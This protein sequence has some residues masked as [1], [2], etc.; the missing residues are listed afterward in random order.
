MSAENIDN[1]SKK[2][3]QK[4]KTSSVGKLDLYIPFFEIALKWVKEDG[5]LGYI[6]VNSFYRSLNGRNLRNFFSK[7]EFLFKLIDFGH[8]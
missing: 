2:L 8:E 6:T 5:V 1:D 7:N 3:A 4:W